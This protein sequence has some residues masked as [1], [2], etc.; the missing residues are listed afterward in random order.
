[1]LKPCSPNFQEKK[2]V[3]GPGGPDSN[4]GQNSKVQNIEKLGF[5]RKI[6]P[7]GPHLNSAFK[8]FLC[9]KSTFKSKI[10][11]IE[12]NQIFQKNHF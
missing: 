12:E 6:D 11:A 8:S 2:I 1:M 3:V 9:I 5:L 7:N 10:E 4:F